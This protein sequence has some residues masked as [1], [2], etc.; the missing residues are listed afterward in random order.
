MSTRALGGFG[1]AS[2]IS[3]GRSATS[4]RRCGHAQFVDLYRRR[5]NPLLEGVCLLYLMF[6]LVLLRNFEDLFVQAL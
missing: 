1:S 4:V 2:G 5:I 3:S 6:N